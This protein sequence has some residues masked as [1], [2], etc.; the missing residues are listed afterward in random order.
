MTVC[1]DLENYTI[2]FQKND[3]VWSSVMLLQNDLRLLVRGQTL[4][5]CLLSEQDVGS[6][7]T[8]VREQSYRFAFDAYREGDAVTIVEMQ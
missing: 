4:F 8:I 1:L 2:A 7:Q 6:P 3:K 5:G